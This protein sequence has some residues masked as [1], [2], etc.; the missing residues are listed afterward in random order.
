VELLV[1]FNDFYK[2]CP[3]DYHEGEKYPVLERDPTRPDLIADILRPL[4]PEPPADSAG[5]K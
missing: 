1:E 5:K 2:T 4:K 3:L